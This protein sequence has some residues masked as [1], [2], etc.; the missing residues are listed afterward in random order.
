MRRWTYVVTL[1]MLNKTP[2]IDEVLN[3][4]PVRLNHTHPLCVGELMEADCEGAHEAR[5]WDSHGLV[6][7]SGR[8]QREIRV[9]QENFAG[10]V[11]MGM[12]VNRRIFAPACLP[13]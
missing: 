11:I 8:T 7:S 13:G 10:G 1:R 5:R 4:Q 12:V 6:R 9:V 2:T 3:L